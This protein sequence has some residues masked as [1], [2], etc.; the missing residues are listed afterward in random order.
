MP[1]L[2]LIHVF[3]ALPV[4]LVLIT[5]TAVLA[6]SVDVERLRALRDKSR[7]T[8]LTAEEQKE[9]DDGRRA[10]EA[11]RAKSQASPTSP[12]SSVSPTTPQTADPRRAE[13]L[14]RQTEEQAQL[15]REGA[16]AF[17]AAA[18]RVAPT[19][20]ARVFFVN[21]ET[22]NDEA[23]GLAE[24][25]S[26]SG[27]PFKTITKAISILRPGDT[28]NLANTKTPYRETIRM[29]DGFGGVP[30]HPITID[31]HGATLTGSDPLRM[32]GWVDAG[33]PGLFKS[34]KLISEIDEATE[35]SKLMRM[36]FIFDGVPQ[37]MGRSSKG[38]RPPFKNPK[39]LKVGEWTY[40][41]A[42]KTFYV[43][44]A[45]GLA[46]AKIEVPYRRNGVMIR[47]Q[48]IAVT[49]VIVKNTVVVH[50]LNDGYNLHG[51]S[52]NVHF[53]NI[54][55][56]ECGDDGISPHGTCEV[57]LDGFWSIGNSTGMGNG[58]VSVTRGK[59]IRLE[60]NTAAQL[61]TAHA[62]VTELQNVV[63][64]ATPGTT[65]LSITNSQGSRLRME[66]S[67]IH[68]PNG[69]KIIVVPD[70]TLE[71]R[72]V[73]VGGAVWEN[74]GNVRITQSVIAGGSISSADPGRWRG[75]KN[76]F[77]AKIS[78]PAGEEKPEKKSLS[79][80]SVLSATAPASDA[81]VDVSRI[82]LPPRPEPNPAAGKFPSLRR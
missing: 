19:E 58:F 4:C 44:V 65:A 22:G 32:D 52:R 61:M 23:D 50:V 42:E 31:G 6:Q 67:Q 62:Q 25:R 43:K 81:G 55:A 75:D 12:A 16:D 11:S 29:N 33:A 37:H 27:G 18:K 40:V 8:K 63:L 36:F 45:A 24:V 1:H 79:V 73:N 9:L 3:R 5:A 47:A 71:L 68:A 66:N 35:D 20:S 69:Q 39:E 26:S 54:A 2:K 59:N 53:E 72:R 76:V 80:E 34:S 77:D 74:S 7:T 78:A 51:S 10:Y 15:R 64:I 41:A 46:D 17:A 48:R 57:T 28:L 14:K 38:A 82:K 70:A 13:Q 56:Y 49:D 60:N 21:N 30:G